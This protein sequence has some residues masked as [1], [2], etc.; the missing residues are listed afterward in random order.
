MQHV[1][2]Y[3][4]N[5]SKLYAKA[6]AQN[7]AYK[8]QYYNALMSAGQ[9][10]REAMMNAARYDDTQYRQADAAKRQYLD[11]ITKGMYGVLNRMEKRNFD[12]NVWKDTYNIYRDD[13]DI[14]RSDLA[15]RM[16]QP[17]ST[18]TPVVKNNYTFLPSNAYMNTS[19]TPF[20]QQVQDYI[21]NP[22]KNR[23]GK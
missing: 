15:Y 20:E 11:T 22:Y 17:L 10:D 1:Q 7:N 23:F 13:Q 12:R 16:S 9:A 2:H 3:I 19:Y 18:T 4:N 5:A 6:D 8:A 21:W 14:K